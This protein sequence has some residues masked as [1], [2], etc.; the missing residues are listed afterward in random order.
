MPFS[1]SRSDTTVH[2]SGGADDA[3]LD[4]TLKPRTARAGDIVTL[5]NLQFLPEN[6]FVPEP[7]FDTYC[8][9]VSL[10][11]HG[12]N[13]LPGLHALIDGARV[14]DVVTNVSVDAGWGARRADLIVRVPVSQWRGR[15]PPTIG[16][17]WR[18]P[19]GIPV[20]ITHLV[21]D[22]IVLDANP[23]LA[24]TSYACSFE[25]VAIDPFG[26]EEDTTTNETRFSMATFALGC[27]WGAELAFLRTEGVVGT[28]VGYSQGHTDQPNYEEVG[29][30]GHRE[31]V[32]VVYDTRIVSYEA[33]V[34]IALSRLKATQGSNSVYDLQRL[35]RLR[36]HDTSADDDDETKQYRHGFY[37]HS[38]EQRDSIER[39]FCQECDACARFEIEVLPASTFWEAEDRH[40]QYLYKGGQSARKGAKQ[41]IRC[42]G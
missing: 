5:R 29:R 19:G 33:L 9:D 12:G 6:G 40:Q 10:V 30:T 17:S 13:Y 25:V 38:N 26:W 34:D 39:I 8:G 42:Y 37:Y 28:R 21:N 23:P 16:K 22:M 20:V 36:N 3:T 35:Y 27:F 18:G 14:G 15:S 11:V 2:P 4:R 1:N 31:S 7:L 24:G 41:P 32:Q